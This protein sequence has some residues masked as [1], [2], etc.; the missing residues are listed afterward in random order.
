M[1]GRA[2]VTTVALVED[3]VLFAE[4]MDVT[5][6]R[7]G[8]DVRRIPVKERAMPGQLL[9]SV[10]RMNPGIALLDLDLGAGGDGTRLVAPLTRS[11]ISVVVVTGSTD[12]ARWGQCLREGARAV[13]S[14]SARL[15]EILS[16]LRLVADGRHVHTGEERQSLITHF[17]TER[18]VVKTVRRRLEL[19][20]AREIEVL[21]HLMDGQPVREIADA[22]FV[23]EA[24]VRTQV[25]SILAKLEV[26]SQLAAVGAARKAGWVPPSRPPSRPS[27]E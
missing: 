24:T 6:T 27:A 22:S 26:T 23:S 19:L 12:R 3:H 1:P 5:L 7:E 20:T 10:M 13:L 8:F 18:E 14:K 17:Y 25:K 2:D 21:A 16:A 9:T 4:A 15:E 11:G